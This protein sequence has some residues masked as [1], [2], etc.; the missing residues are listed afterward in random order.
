MVHALAL[1]AAIL[2]A[3][4]LITLA[5][6]WHGNAAAVVGTTVYGITLIAMILCSALY[7]IWDSSEWTA[8]FRRLD[9]SAIYFKIAGTY[10]PFILLSGGQDGYLLVALWTAAFA[11][12]ALRILAPERMRWVAIG[13]YLLMGWAIVFAGQNLLAAL[14]PHVV[15]LM[16]VGGVLYTAGVAFYLFERMPFHNTI[17]HV[18]VMAASVI[19]FAAVTAQVAE[20]R[21]PAGAVELAPA[22]VA[23]E[24]SAA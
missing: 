12:T 22:E 8:L 2:A 20:T 24:P 14:P 7:N 1:S 13:L 16:I 23:V 3:P 15:W 11:G 4:V 6:V 18:F 17:W 19:F 10:T 9:H 5:S 21:H